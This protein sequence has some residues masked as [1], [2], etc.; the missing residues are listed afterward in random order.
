MAAPGFG[1]D[2][3]SVFRKSLP[4][5]H[6]RQHIFPSHSET[7]ARNMAL[8]QRRQHGRYPGKILP[9]EM[10]EHRIEKREGCRSFYTGQVLNNWIEVVQ[11]VRISERS[12]KFFSR[13]SDIGR[14]TSDYFPSYTASPTKS[15]SSHPVTFTL[16]NAPASSAKSECMAI[17]LS[18]SGASA[19]VRPK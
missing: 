10:R 4:L 5:L 9:F 1:Q 16:A 2:Y 6:N 3:P 13:T 18:T 11:V 17:S 14:R 7:S 12:P 8:Q 15:N 19:S